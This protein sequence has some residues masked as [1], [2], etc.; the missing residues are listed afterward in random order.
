MVATKQ[1]ACQVSRAAVAFWLVISPV[2]QQ[3]HGKKPF[4][5]RD[6][7]R[8]PA[9]TSRNHQA[10]R[11]LML[12]FR[13][14]VLLCWALIIPSLA[15]ACT[16]TAPSS[17]GP[18][19]IDLTLHA[20][21]EFLTH[22]GAA[23][24]T[25]FPDGSDCANRPSIK[26]TAAPCA[27]VNLT[28][29]AS[30][31]L[32]SPVPGIAADDCRTLDPSL[33]SGN[34][35]YTEGFN[36]KIRWRPLFTQSLEFLLIEHGFRFASDSYARYL[37]FHKP[38]WD[39]W[40]S[41]VQHFDMSRWGD[42]DDFLVNY[43]G[44]PLEGAVSGR[45]FIQNDPRGRAERFGKSGS[46]WKSRL[47]AMAWA[48]AYSAYFEIGPVLSEAAFGNEGGFTYVPKC[49]LAPCSIPGRKLKPPTNNTGWVDF[50]VTPTVGIS[51]HSRDTSGFA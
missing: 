51:S 3:L 39:D 17:K 38:F 8:I 6:P 12:H 26:T 40:G 45:I 35:Q 4:W 25:D 15:A 32:N 36:E 20:R 42:G 47:R 19:S 10:F 37:L 34:P 1:I 13:H 5:L 16:Q 28:S 29:L 27:S 33:A 50:V 22:P 11:N 49:G 44:H 48:A 2:S 41:S 9:V 24:P 18:L 7:P 14:C 43:I 31:A 21:P 23:P 30:G 46:Y